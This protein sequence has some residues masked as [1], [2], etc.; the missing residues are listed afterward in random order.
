MGL[1][2][3][4]HP[5]AV[6]PN[7]LRSVYGERRFDRVIVFGVQR[8]GRY[9]VLSHLASGGMGQVYLARATGLGGFERQVVVKTLDLSILS[10]TDEN[11]AFVTMFLDE[12]RLVGALHHQYIAPVYE[13]GC[14]ED[15][16]YYLVMDYVHGETAEA[17][18]RVS[19]ER[20]QPLPL[21]FSLTVV[22]CIAS[23]L[24]YA[25]SLC[26]ADGTPLDIVHRDVSLSNVMCGHDGAVRLIDFG[27]AKA[28]NRATKTQVGT[29]KGKIGYLAPEQILRHAVD[30]R[31][32]IFA[33]GIVLY[34]LTTGVRAFRDTSDLVTLERICAGDVRPPS[35]LVTGYPAELERIVMKALR[36]DPA[37]RF[38]GAGV[39]GRALEQLAAR[40]SLRLGHAAIADVMGGLF[41]DRR[42]GRR[43]IA[44]GSYEV[45]TDQVIASLPAASVA[46]GHAAEDE[47]TP[48]T[49]VTST[50]EADTLDADTRSVAFARSQRPTTP[51]VDRKR[52]APLAVPVEV[53]LEDRPTAIVDPAVELRAT[54]ALIP[55]EDR[56]TP[57]AEPPALPLPPQRPLVTTPMPHRTTRLGTGPIKPVRRGT[58]EEVLAR[59]ESTQR[60]IV[61]PSSGQPAIPSTATNPQPAVSCTPTGLQP[62]LTSRAEPSRTPTGPHPALASRVPTGPQ[63]PATSRAPTGPQPLATSPTG[64]QPPCAREDAATESAPTLDED[65]TLAIGAK[66]CERDDPTDVADADETG[67]HVAT[68]RPKWGNAHLAIAVVSR[69]P[70]AP[71]AP[72]RTW[73]LL[74]VLFVIA[75]LVASVVAMI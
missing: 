17:L 49:D 31:A 14:D 23:A 38:Q 67:P 47:E 73:L 26:A 12:A 62:P 57:I 66:L 25:H 56:P 48:I 37:R 21:A 59:G 7:T 55:L 16:R 70:R 35:E 58:G 41:P 33:L 54:H 34:E 10:I 22:S 42:R 53:P 60:P 15:G 43:R 63:P 1:T 39:L 32:D 64:P 13:V 61:T 4:V 28:A 52:A 20:A 50:L 71:A 74:C 40:L 36:V 24:D 5:R 9:E 27:I 45:K 30:H 51:I 3:A 8:I 44:R 6:C 18:F 46:E 75:A 11:E 65:T 69:M 19:S 2:S 72:L 29:L 68:P